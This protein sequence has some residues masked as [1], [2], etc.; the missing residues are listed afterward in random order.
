MKHDEQ[1]YQQIEAYLAGTLSEAEREAFAIQLKAD[2]E[3][4]QALTLHREMELQYD[5]QDWAVLDSG[6]TDAQEAYQGYFQSEAAK[7]LQ[8]ALRKADTQIGQRGGR[9]RSLS[10]RNWILLAAAVVGLLILL[11]GLWPRSQGTEALY[12]QY[13]QHSPLQLIEKG[14]EASGLALFEQRFNAKGYSAA[15]EALTPDLN[16]DSANYSLQLAIGIAYL[17]TGQFVQARQRFNRIA[18]STALLREEGEWYL[19]LTDLKEG[20]VEE[21]KTRLETIVAM[22]HHER[23]DDAR[24]LLGD[25]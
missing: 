19:A 2:A 12:Q 16:L 22:D 5:E 13:A 23:M 24:E 4:A 11:A 17:E 18:Q 15:L 20:Q 3:L 14:G 9:I 7:S 8:E 6:S 21:C 25:L 1:T 10:R